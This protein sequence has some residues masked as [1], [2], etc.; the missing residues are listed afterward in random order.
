VLPWPEATSLTNIDRKIKEIEAH[1]SKHD[2][3]NLDALVSFVNIRG[4]QETCDDLL[5]P[6]E[7]H[8]EDDG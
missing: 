1:N 5:G 7:Q 4:R 2:C 8:D 3:H 6:D